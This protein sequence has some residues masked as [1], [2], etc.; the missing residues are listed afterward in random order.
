MTTFSASV[1]EPLDIDYCLSLPDSNARRAFAKDFF[2]KLAEEFSQLKSARYPKI[3][4]VT[5][6][7]G[8]SV[9]LTFGKMVLL[10]EDLPESVVNNMRML[11]W[12]DRI[13]T[14]DKFISYT[15]K[16]DSWKK[17]Q[18]EEALNADRAKIGDA[19]RGGVE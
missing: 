5:S 3:W 11:L 18:Y 17:T 2:K 19:L 7:I 8:H 16:V 15:G 1:V 6:G 14:R 12:L 4:V 9:E 13:H 10:K